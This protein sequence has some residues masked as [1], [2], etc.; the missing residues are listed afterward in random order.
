MYKILIEKS[1]YKDLDK[2]SA[3]DLNKIYQNII[4]LEREP[5][6]FG[7]KKL[8]GYKNR[9]RIRQGDYR[10]VYIIDDAANI[11]RVMLVRHRKDVYQDLP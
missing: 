7:A 2:I 6:P 1:V 10:I 5:R 9:Y 3:Q 4:Q 11:I 8:K